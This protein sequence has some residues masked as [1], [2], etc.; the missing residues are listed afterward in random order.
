MSLGE[1]C[2]ERHRELGACPICAGL[3]MGLALQ[4]LRILLFWKHL[5]CHRPMSLHTVRL[6]QLKP[7]PPMAA[8]PGTSDA[9]LGGIQ[10]AAATLL[11]WQREEEGAERM[12]RVR[13]V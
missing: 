9:I 6:H 11:R 12:W 5:E 1:V 2:R 10:A 7:L 4:N 13:S 8:P 3:P